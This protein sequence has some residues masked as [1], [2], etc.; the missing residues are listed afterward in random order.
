M[1]PATDVEKEDALALCP[2]SMVDGD[3]VATDGDDGVWVQAWIF[4]GK[5]ETEAA[6]DIL[7]PVPQWVVHARMNDGQKAEWHMDRDEDGP[8]AAAAIVKA[9]PGVRSALCLVN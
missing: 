5:P 6:P 3:A 2:G 4:I 9:Q 1:R 7:V 8:D